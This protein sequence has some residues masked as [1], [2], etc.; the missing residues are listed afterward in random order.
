M[1]LIGIAGLGRAERLLVPRA[2]A[3]HEV[4]PER[5]GVVA[6]LGSKLNTTFTS[7]QTALK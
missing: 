7:V 2:D 4:I 5:P 6:G 3:F 1:G